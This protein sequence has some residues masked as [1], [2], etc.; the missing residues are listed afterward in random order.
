MIFLIENFKFILYLKLQVNNDMDPEL[1]EL[2]SRS[3]I[4]IDVNIPLY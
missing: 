2:Y 4:H 1:I 3:I